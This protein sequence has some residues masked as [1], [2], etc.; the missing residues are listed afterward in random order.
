[1]RKLDGGART[2][3][4]NKCQ[5]AP[6]SKF[7]EKKQEVLKGVD[8]KEVAK[9]E[10][11]EID[12]KVAKK[13][14]VMDKFEVDVPYDYVPLIFEPENPHYKDMFETITHEQAREIPDQ[15]LR[16]FLVKVNSPKN[17]RKKSLLCLRTGTI[18]MVMLTRATKTAW[19]ML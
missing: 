13:Y 14:R 11:K 7:E 2:K 3:N 18:S 4:T 5:K 12:K 15:F 9:S 6:K 8:K 19:S 1:M 10:F 17:L 16:T